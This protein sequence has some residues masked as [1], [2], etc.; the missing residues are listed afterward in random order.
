MRAL[1]GGSEAATQASAETALR[2]D[3]AP[4]RCVQRADSVRREF[5]PVW[6]LTADTRPLAFDGGGV[7]MRATVWMLADTDGPPVRYS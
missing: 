6:T 1:G 4:V 5:M 3:Y 2:C 7:G